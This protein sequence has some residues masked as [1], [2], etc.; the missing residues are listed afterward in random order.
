MSGPPPLK[1]TNEWPNGPAYL[2]AHPEVRTKDYEPGEALPLGAPVHFESDLFKGSVFLRL[3]PN[4]TNPDDKAA[5]TAYF[6]KKKRLWQVVV[7]G[8]FKE[9]ID[10]SDLLL[11]DFYEKPMVGIPKGSIMKVYQ[12][13]MEAISP[14]IVMDMISDK[15]KI[16]TPFGA[17]TQTMRVDL[18]GNEPEITAAAGNM[19]EDA[20]LLLGKE[21]SSKTS[22]KSRRK[23]LSKPKNSSKYK[24]NP[25]HVYTF[26]MYDHSMNFGTYHQHVFGNYKIDMV[27]SMNGQALAFCLFTRDKRIVWKFPLWHERLIEDMKKKQA[28]QGAN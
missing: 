27:D 1:D 14:G 21:F 11:G 10:L 12:K 4:E 18:P 28:A 6:H 22:S 15:P 7:Q 17:N 5:H 9:E 19:Q 3:R 25:A 16:L 13:F 24:V 26:E 23:Y 2:C 20:S 8:Q